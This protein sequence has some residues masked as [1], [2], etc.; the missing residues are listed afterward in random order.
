MNADRAVSGGRSCGRGVSVCPDH[1]P[2]RARAVAASRYGASGVA[3]F[4]R[5][6]HREAA[7]CA[8]PEIVDS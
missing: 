7:R 1:D 8:N 4:A 5:F 3:I 6:P 2:G